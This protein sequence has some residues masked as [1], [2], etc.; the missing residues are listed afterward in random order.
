MSAA[1]Q[2]VS[3]PPDPPRA[4]RHPHRLVSHGDERVD[5]WFWLRDRDNPDT[6]AYLEAENAYADLALAPTVDLQQR[7]FGEI[8]ARILETDVSAPTRHGPWWYYRRTLEGLPYGIHCRQPD[9]ERRL[10]AADVL[11]SAGAV[12][13]LASD[14]AEQVLLD[15]NDL[16]A[17]SDAFAL[18]VLDVSP[19]H[20][21]M[22]YATD[23]I[24]AERY[25]LRFR[26]LEA[27]NDLD[28]TVEGVYY[29]SAW[30]AD[31]RTFFYTRPDEA[32]RPW[33][34]W[35]HE[36]G[37]PPSEDALVFQ[38][39][40][41]HFFVQLDQTRSERFIVI[42][43]ESK[44]TSEVRFIDTGRPAET[45]RVIEPRRHGVE[46]EVEHGVLPLDGGA[47]DCWLIL[48]NADGAENFA[49]H[50]APADDPGRP[51]WRALI[52]HR[53]AVRLEAVEAF[54]GQLVVSE[55]EQ[56]L[57]HLRVMG[58]D[59]AAR[60][61]AG[62]PVGPG[63]PAPAGVPGRRLDQPEPVYSI[64]GADNPEFDATAYRFGYTSLVTPESVIEHHFGTGERTVIKQQPVLGGYNPDRYRT[65]RL[66]ATAPD[67]T[68][69]PM[70]VVH[71]RDVALDSSAPCVLYGY[72]S[73]EITIDPA[74]SSARLNLLERGFVYAIAHIRGGGELGRPWYEHGKLRHKRNT[75][76]DFIASAEHL[77]SSGYTRP[78][79][80][81]IRGGSAGGLLVGAVIN[82]RPDLFAGAVAEV[83][84]VD[85]LTTMQDE[86][87]PLTVTEWEEWGNPVEDPEDYAYMKSY[88]PYDNVGEH[89]YPA[90][91]VTAGLNDPRVG[92]WEPAKWVAKLRDRGA[93][94][95]LVVLR[96]EMGA[97]HAGPTG[98]YEAW[99]DE[100]RVQAFILAVAGGSG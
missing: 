70:S 98:R 53:P 90:L 82:L 62:A 14:A 3:V 18:G 26:D 39:D 37:R 50:V 74:F 96:T 60:A 83:P 73:Y 54:T 29:G 42:T 41:G 55:R 34:V 5:D 31:S 78:E 58:V 61:V 8:K 35:R 77:I 94:N 24:G 67:G 64:R 57:E 97:G 71:R 65:D 30:A 81:V 95:G 69:V 87:L 86:T 2:R 72:G 11:A 1:D 91:Y 4:P 22:A 23:L 100:A 20:R 16:A 10:T 28:D 66:W 21:L 32:M 15:E 36:V 51:S 44:V 76:S 7:L 79:R 75:F 17:G 63:G 88:S 40:D 6:I 9:P 85:C 33:Q 48:S 43:S 38:E 46:Y 52:P 80:L 84:F 89:G 56:G 12:P 45:P 68:A 59:E 25:T 27:G 13:A 92:F 99:R 93:G 47:R 19:D 49:L